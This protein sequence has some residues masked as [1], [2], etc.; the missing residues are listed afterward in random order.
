M[1]IYIYIYIYLE[2]FISYAFGSNNWCLSDHIKYMLEK[3]G[4][5]HNNLAISLS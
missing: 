3:N 2:N 1:Y 5:E 4:F